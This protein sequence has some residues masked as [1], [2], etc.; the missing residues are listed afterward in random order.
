MDRFPAKKKTQPLDDPKNPAIL[1]NQPQM[2]ANFLARYNRDQ[3]NYHLQWVIANRQI[4][5]V[6]LTANGNTCNATI[7][8]SFPVAVTDTKGFTTEQYG[9]DPLTVWVQLSGSPVSF[10]LSTPIPL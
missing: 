8:V 9:S 2:S 10:T 7:P 3:C 5:G 4:T 6:T 1:T